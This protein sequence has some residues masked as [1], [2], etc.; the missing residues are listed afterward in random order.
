M[1]PATALGRNYGHGFGKGL[2]PWSSLGA[3][4]QGSPIPT[5]IP[6]ARRAGRVAAANAPR[7]EESGRSDCAAAPKATAS[8]SARRGASARSASRF[9]KKPRPLS[10]LLSADHALWGEMSLLKEP[11]PR[12]SDSSL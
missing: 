6:D 12:L 4:A 10:G 9:L 8:L 11:R 2:R 5:F 1:L 7:F 3:A